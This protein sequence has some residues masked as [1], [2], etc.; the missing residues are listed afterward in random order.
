MFEAGSADA[1]WLPLSLF[2]GASGAAHW[3][4]TAWDSLDDR[5]RDMLIQRHEDKTLAAIGRSH[6]VTRERARQIVIGASKILREEALATRAMWKPQLEELF[7]NASAVP[8][9]A[10]TSIFVD[11]K[12]TARYAL[13]RELGFEH[14]RTWAGPLRQFWTREPGDLDRQ[15]RDLAKYGPYRAEELVP[16][17]VALGVPESVPVASIAAHRKSPLLRADGMWVRRSSRG[18]DAV[19]LWLADEG[20]PRHIED[21]VAALGGDGRAVKESLRRDERFRQIRPEGTWALREWPLNGTTEYTNALDAVLGVLAE[22]GPMTRG[23]LYRETARRYTVTYSRVLQCLLSDRIGIAAGASKMVDLVER[24]ALPLE[25][26]EPKRPANVAIDDSGK[27]IG[28]KVRVDAEVLRGSGVIIHRWITW[29]LGLRQAPMS[30]TFSLTDFTGELTLTRNTSAAHI[31]S[32]R[33]YAETMGLAL[34]CELAVVLRLEVGTARLQHACA[35]EDCP[36][37]GSLDGR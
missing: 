25:E 30:R 18:R 10:L 35:P 21:M 33:A 37:G 1:Q 34:G 5:Q 7:L 24:G 27:V 19:Y 28:F 26:R 22:L 36:A 13:L 4:P 3:L 15:L 12:G 9:D 6:G 16:R 32:L 2:E 20:S 14:P 31:S 8:E 11:P 23:N 17:A 29:R